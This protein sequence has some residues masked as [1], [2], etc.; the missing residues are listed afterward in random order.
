MMR[1][2]YILSIVLLV[3]WCSRLEP[4]SVW[5]LDQYVDTGTNYLDMRWQNLSSIPDVCK[6]LSDSY[7]D[8]LERIDFS[9]N[10]IEKLSFSDLDCL[11]SLQE[12]DLSYNQIT[13]VRKIQPI[14]TL[15][16]LFL[17]QNAI[18]DI[19]W[20][21]V[22]I[23]LRTLNLAYNDIMD[24]SPLVNLSSLI[25]LQLQHNNIVDIESLSSLVWL[26]SLKLEFNQLDDEQSLY[27]QPLLRL[28]FLS[29]GE[30]LMDQSTIDAW[31]ST[32]NW[33]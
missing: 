12:I 25:D 29:V 9:N 5:S 27:F 19:S 32:I 13:T 22:L 21:S 28:R 4:I 10:A 31:Q 14:A 33:Q 16:S 20:L 17:H 1:I 7:H 18:K 8:T 30:N 24:V 15:T 11:S 26:Q 6:W 23:W 3:A 2:V